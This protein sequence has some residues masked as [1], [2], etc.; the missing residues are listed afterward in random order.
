MNRSG[1]LQ[2][3]FRHGM[4]TEVAAGDHPI[5]AAHAKMF[6]EIQRQAAPTS[7]PPKTKNRPVGEPWHGDKR[8]SQECPEPA[9]A[10]GQAGWVK[11]TSMLNDLAKEDEWIWDSGGPPPF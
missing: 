6:D 10:D 2:Y 9:G 3:V 5:N 8:V 1:F 4:S 11:N 7:D